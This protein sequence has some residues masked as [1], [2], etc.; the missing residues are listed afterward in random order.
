MD[1]EIDH[2]ATRRDFRSGT[3]SSTDLSANPW[4]QMARWLQDAEAA[5][6]FDPTAM[7]LATADE[8]GQPSVRFVLLKHFDERGIC[9][10]TDSRSQ[11]G[12][13]LAVNPKGAVVFYWPELDRQ[14]RLAGA[15]ELLPEQDAESYFHQ[16][17]LG[18]R[19]AAAASIQS[20]P[21]A[22]RALLEARVQELAQGF[23][24]GNVPRNAA[25][26]GYRLVPTSFEFWQGRRNRLHDRFRYL[27]S[28]EG[29][30]S[31]TRL[32]P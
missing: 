20:Q 23:P 15:V 3:L 25:W 16:R 4:E 18:S 9:W 21:I 31:I 27:R 24:E 5:G 30:W 26:M 12:Q 7:A 28:S 1:G 17:P 8:Q 19:L 6:N 11:K 10:Y 32:M 13:E 22:N 14:L 29:S 2:R